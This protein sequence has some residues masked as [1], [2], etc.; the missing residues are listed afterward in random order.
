MADIFWQNF[1]LNEFIMEHMG[2][3]DIMHHASL[4]SVCTVHLTDHPIVGKKL[5]LE[6]LLHNT[7]LML[8]NFFVN[9]WHSR[10]TLI[11]VL[12]VG[13]GTYYIRYNRKKVENR[14]ESILLSMQENH[15]FFMNSSNFIFAICNSSLFYLLIKCQPNYMSQDKNIQTNGHTYE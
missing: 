6:T 1:I 3:F 2:L 10:W 13:Y 9:Q 7:L 12:V 11:S 14:I 5:N 15:S 8:I 4:S